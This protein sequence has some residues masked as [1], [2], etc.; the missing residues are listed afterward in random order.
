MAPTIRP[1]HPRHPHTIRRLVVGVSRVA[2]ETLLLFIIIASLVGHFE[3]N[4]TSMEPNLHAGQRIIVSQIGGAL[5]PPFGRTVHA[6][7]GE[8][9]VSSVLRRGQVVVFY[10][11]PPQPASIPLIKRLIGLPGDTIEIRDGQVFINNRL[12]DEPYV[13]GKL[14]TGGRYGGPLIL[15]DA[16]YFFMGDNRPNSRDSRHFGPIP[17]DQIVGLVVI[18]YWPLD[19]LS[20]D[21]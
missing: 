17:A 2:V 7:P 18:R 9:H 8:S 12:L 20:M 1:S 13:H 15:G 4:Q 16:E 10:D 3:I 19:Q 6:A 21:F 11:Q 14:T 5:H